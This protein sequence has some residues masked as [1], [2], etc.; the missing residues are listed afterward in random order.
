MLNVFALVLRIVNYFL[1]IDHLLYRIGRSNRLG[2]ENARGVLDL[3]SDV[4]LVLFSASKD[5]LEESLR[6]SYLL[7]VQFVALSGREIFHSDVVPGEVILRERDSPV[8]FLDM[9]RRSKF[10]VRV[11]LFRHHQLFDCLPILLQFCIL[12]VIFVG[13]VHR[14]ILW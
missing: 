12:R 10:K 4:L 14:L 5:L 1:F 7:C 3:P 2:E 9:H 8:K 6:V 11:S 13:I